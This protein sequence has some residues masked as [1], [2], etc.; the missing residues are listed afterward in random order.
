[1]MEYVVSHQEEFNKVA[2][3]QRKV[4]EILQCVAADL[5]AL[6]LTSAA[7]LFV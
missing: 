3:V 2:L 6:H 5:N 1:M 7:G 4:K